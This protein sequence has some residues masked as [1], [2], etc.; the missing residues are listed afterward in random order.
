LE[1]ASLEIIE[2]PGRA[3]CCL[4]GGIVILERPFGLCA[5]G[6]SDLQWISGE[7][8]TIKAMEVT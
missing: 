8:L 5:C 6:S 7:E 2:T 1:G 3:S 4:C